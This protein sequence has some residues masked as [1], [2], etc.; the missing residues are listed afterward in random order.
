MAIGSVDYSQKLADVRERYDNSLDDMRDSHRKDIRERE[1]HARKIRKKRSDN[2]LRQKNEME[3][4]F[5]KTR[6]RQEKL[7]S[8][9]IKEIKNRYKNNW[10]EEKTDFDRNRTKTQRD[11]AE[12]LASISDSYRNSFESLELAQEHEKEA[13]DAKL[14]RNLA[15]LQNKFDE[16]VDDIEER[17]YRSEMKR[18]EEAVDVRKKIREERNLYNEKLAKNNA[19]WET[20]LAEFAGRRNDNQKQY[21][22]KLNNKHERRIERFKNELDKNAVEREDFA[23][24][25]ADELKKQVAKNKLYNQKIIEERERHYRDYIKNNV[26]ARNSKLVDKF[27]RRHDEMEFQMN[28]KSV[29]ADREIRNKVD[30]AK[31]RYAK[32]LSDVESKGVEKMEDIR[33]GYIRDKNDALART[34]EKFRGQVDNLRDK[35]GKKHALKENSLQQKIDKKNYEKEQVVRFYENQLD[36]L[37]SVAAKEFD[38]ITKLAN[39]QRSA[40]KKDFARIMQNRNLDFKRQIDNL[41]RG[42]DKQVAAGKLAQEERNE[43]LADKYENMLGKE[44]KSYEKEMARNARS[45]REEYERLVNRLALERES[46]IA[47]YEAKIEN[48]QYANG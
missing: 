30:W 8:N 17:N 11:Y 9:K 39:L 40:D 27:Q 45:F 14:K 24:W 36:Q 16:S 28:R 23:K 3:E 32:E 12:R 5:A 19:D 47:Q 41:I 1:E 42:F 20:E 6:D 25:S 21:V 38:H 22:E 34:E 18:N 15:S 48:M 2:H 29:E 13:R 26:K 43:K 4:E 33:S 44:R 10:E 46:L 35:L 7:I 37:K 31:T